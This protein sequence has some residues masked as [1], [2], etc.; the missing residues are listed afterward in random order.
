MYR[1]VIT[2]GM[3]KLGH[4]ALKK[5]K[6]QDLNRLDRLVMSFPLAVCRD[7]V[8]FSANGNVVVLGKKEEGL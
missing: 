3:K 8:N 4:T 2:R 5:G 7:M 6:L 1:N